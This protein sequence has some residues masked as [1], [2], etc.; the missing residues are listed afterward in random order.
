MNT[1][2]GERLTAKIY[3]RVST[4]EQHTEN[5]IPECAQLANA[6]GFEVLETVE[7]DISTRKRRP[8]LERLIEE[9]RRGAFRVLVVWKLDRFGR[10]MVGNLLDVLG[11]LE[12]GVQVVSVTESWMDTSNPLIRKL[13]LA[14]FSW[15]AEQ[16]RET[17]GERTRAGMARAIRQGRIPGRRPKP[18]DVEAVRALEREGIDRKE[19]AR[20]LRVGRST[21]YRF[22]RPHDEAT[23]NQGQAPA[24][25]AEAAPF[26]PIEPKPEAPPALPPAEPDA[27]QVQRERLEALPMR[28]I[29]WTRGARPFHGTPPTPKE[30][31]I[32]IAK[33]PRT[34]AQLCAI[35]PAVRPAWITDRLSVV[36]HAGFAKTREDR[37]WY[38]TPEGRSA[39]GLPPEAQHV[40]SPHAEAER[41]P[42]ERIEP[43]PS[44]VSGAQL[45]E[46]PAHVDEVPAPARP[47][48]VAA[49]TRRAERERSEENCA[50]C[51]LS[52]RVEG[53]N[54]C[55][56]CE[57][58]VE[59]AV[60]HVRREQKA[61]ELGD[62][63]PLLDD[64]EAL[65]GVALGKRYRM[66][67]LALVDAHRRK[68]L[69]IGA[70]NQR[71]IVFDPCAVRRPAAR[72][73]APTKAKKRPPKKRPRRGGARRAA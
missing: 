6:R 57:R 62:L 55:T 27:A 10:D 60:L 72:R 33:E 52:P 59:R 18:I 32:A 35:W 50:A 53:R 14:I 36:K 73:K 11:L 20:R 54:L 67:H 69:A 70:D 2:K 65:P 5:Q 30:I 64:P 7:E 17:R 15:V 41:A 1:T 66:I 28:P 19:I 68:V 44:T 22:M 26:A 16:E 61:I 45:V 46:E 49:A 24:E 39:L 8:G 25:V 56:T 37:R 71:A 31:L 38:L 4:G 47:S 29:G 48:L 34:H 13:L 63:L 51:A 3:A 42:E 58:F 9:A 43:A 12:I 23:E 21:L 40:E